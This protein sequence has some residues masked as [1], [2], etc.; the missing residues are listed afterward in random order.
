MF[1]LDGFCCQ[2]WFT[3]AMLI[4]SYHTELIL[5]ILV[6]ILSYGLTTLYDPRYFLPP[7]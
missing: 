1:G 4:D 5:L 7:A 2:K 6:K 3:L